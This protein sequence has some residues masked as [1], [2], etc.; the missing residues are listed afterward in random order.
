MTI[1][2]ECPECGV[3][4]DLEFNAIGV[5]D[6]E[7]FWG[8]PVSIESIEDEFEC[9]LKCPECGCRLDEDRLLDDA[10]GLVTA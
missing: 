6:H 8:A 4:I 10:I 9:D 1:T 2:P 7:E 5:T 3:D